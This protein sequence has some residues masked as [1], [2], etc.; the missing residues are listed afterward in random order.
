MSQ[1]DFLLSVSIFKKN[2]IT[3]TISFI[4]HFSAGAKIIH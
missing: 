1:K 3:S 4:H 2:L